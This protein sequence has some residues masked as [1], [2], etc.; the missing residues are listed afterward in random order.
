MLHDQRLDGWRNALGRG[1]LTCLPGELS[2]GGGFSGELAL[3][4]ETMSVWKQ[5]GLTFPSVA[6]LYGYRHCVRAAEEMDSKFIGLC[7]QGVRIPSMS[8]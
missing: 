7:P 5:G 3:V 1:Q 8:L 4:W 6:A 2:V